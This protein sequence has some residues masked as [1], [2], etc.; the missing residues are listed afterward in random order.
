MMAIVLISPNNILQGINVNDHVLSTME[1]I[2]RMR[3]FTMTHGDHYDL[4]D[5]IGAEEGK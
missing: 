1:S 5:V 3:T 2:Q 4:D